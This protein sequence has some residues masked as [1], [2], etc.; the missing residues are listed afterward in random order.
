MRPKKTNNIINYSL[1]H[2][3]IKKQLT[4]KETKNSVLVM[5]HI[6]Y[7]YKKKLIELNTTTRETNGKKLNRKFILNQGTHEQSMS[8]AKAY[9]ITIKHL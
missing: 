8:K 7:A 2:K 3:K 9:E 5:K 1:W 4:L 6:D